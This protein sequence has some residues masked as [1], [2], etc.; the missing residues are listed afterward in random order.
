MALRLRTEKE[1]IQVD[2]RA[3]N[4]NPDSEVLA[5]FFVSPMTP[6]ELDVVL[7]KH[8]K[9]DWVSPNRKTKKELVK[10][11]NYMEVQKERIVETIVGWE[12][13]NNSQGEILECTKENKLSVWAYNPE[14]IGW[15][16][17]QVDEIQENREVKKEEEVKN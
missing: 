14:V 13:V 6:Q 15:V 12:G 5:V 10:E 17:D 1:T 3:D 11:P 8:E 7:K 2:Y 16:L 4:N 9:K